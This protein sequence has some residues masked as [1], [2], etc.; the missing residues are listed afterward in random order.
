MPAGHDAR[1]EEHGCLSGSGLPQKLAGQDG[2]ARRVLIGAERSQQLSGLAPLLLDG[3][4]EGA[5]AV[6]RAR[7]PVGAPLD[8][9]L[10]HRGVSARRSDVQRRQAEKI[11]AVS[12]H[13]EADQPV[14]QFRGTTLGSVVEPQAPAFALAKRI[15]SLA[16]A[17]F[18]VRQTPDLQGPDQRHHADRRLHCW[19]APASRE[20]V[21]GSLSVSSIDGL[22]E[23]G[24][25]AGERVDV[26]S[27]LQQQSRHPNLLRVEQRRP[28][29]RV[30]GVGAGPL[31]DQEPGDRQIVQIDRDV[32]GCGPAGV[33]RIQQRW[34]ALDQRSNLHPVALA[35]GVEDLPG[36]G[37]TAGTRLRRPQLLQHPGADPV[38][39]GLRRI[40]QEPP[41]GRHRRDGGRSLPEGLAERNGLSPGPI[42]PAEAHVEHLIVVEDEERLVGCNRRVKDRSVDASRIGESHVLRHR[43]PVAAASKPSSKDARARRPLDAEVDVPVPRGRCVH[44]VPHPPG[45]RPA[46]GRPLDQPDPVGLRRPRGAK[47]QPCVVE[48]QVSQVVTIAPVER[49]G[50]RGRPALLVQPGHHDDHA[51]IEVELLPVG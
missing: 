24:L 6:V 37:G 1:G 42:G 50:L 33:S 13:A 43:L 44:P 10:D 36:L 48:G 30:A 26:G 4:V 14:D 51:T 31:L 2:K 45:L 20:Q 17:L 8:Q 5:L 15:Q 27:R 16:E 47:E 18:E 35:N 9:P 25:V 7:V 19:N 32:E 22:R 29:N 49:G 3:Q 46:G 21:F 39:V 23:G 12:G 41:V 38:H 40:E 34:I 11:P 28:V